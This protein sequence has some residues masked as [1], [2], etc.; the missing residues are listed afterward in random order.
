MANLLYANLPSMLTIRMNAVNTAGA[1][2]G[3]Y[4]MSTPFDFHFK[5]I[6]IIFFVFTL[7]IFILLYFIRKDE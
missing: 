4:G 1:Y 7:T 6:Q 5:C 2:N 3:L